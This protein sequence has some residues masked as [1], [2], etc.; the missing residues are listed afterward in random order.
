MNQPSH[1]RPQLNATLR[2]YNIATMS[3]LDQT[4][5]LSTLIREACTRFSSYAGIRQLGETLDSCGDESNI[6][7]EDFL[8][9]LQEVRLWFYCCQLNNLML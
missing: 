2:L 6:S 1:A 9:Q 7:A 3:Q 8:Q 5:Q 4:D